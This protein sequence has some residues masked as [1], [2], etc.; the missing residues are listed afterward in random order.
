MATQNHKQKEDTEMDLTVEKLLETISLLDEERIKQT[1][2]NHR[3]AL[4]KACHAKLISP[5]IFKEYRALKKRVFNTKED[6]MSFEPFKEEDIRKAIEENNLIKNHKWSLWIPLVFLM[7]PENKFI[8]SRS[9]LEIIDR[10]GYARK[11]EDVRYCDLQKSLNN[12]L[13]NGF[14]ERKNFTKWGDFFGKE[15]TREEKRA[16]CEEN[17]HGFTPVRFS[18]V[19]S[20]FC[21]TG[22]GRARALEIFEEL[23]NAEIIAGEEN[24]GKITPEITINNVPVDYTESNIIGSL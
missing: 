24:D 18:G 2:A 4:D 11:R 23:K 6:I 19:Q 8:P 20:V 3:K 7:I 16:W 10:W 14:F 5:L 15:N 17:V 21:L 13:K 9:I 1:L 12:L 22:K